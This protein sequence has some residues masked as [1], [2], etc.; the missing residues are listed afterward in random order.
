MVTCLCKFK[1]AL[2]MS[3][4]YRNMIDSSWH[5]TTH[6]FHLQLTLNYH[7][8]DNVIHV[9]DKKVSSPQPVGRLSCHQA[10]W[11]GPPGSALSPRLVQE[12]AGLPV[13]REQHFRVISVK[14]WLSTLSLS[15]LIHSQLPLWSKQ[16]PP[17]FSTTLKNN[18]FQGRDFNASIQ[19]N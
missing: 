19:I 2:G 9:C 17:P 18:N 14:S 16:L 13:R 11:H 4:K 10:R 3:V 15:G 7:L 6:M 5:T 8:N 12:S 1:G